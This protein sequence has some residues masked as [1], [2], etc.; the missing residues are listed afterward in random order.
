MKFNCLNR[1]PEK[2]VI[3]ARIMKCFMANPGIPGLWRDKERERARSFSTLFTLLVLFSNLS[4][5][6]DQRTQEFMA[7][8]NLHIVGS[9]GDLPT[10]SSRHEENRGGIRFE[11]CPML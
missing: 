7:L 10:R 8:R 11:I 9:L 2:S 4:A 3:E 5:N 6:T 1:I